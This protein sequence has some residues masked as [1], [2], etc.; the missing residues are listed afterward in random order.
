MCGARNDITESL[1]QIG[2]SAADA[3][4]FSIP[5]AVLRDLAAVVPLLPEGRVHPEIE[6]D[7]DDGSIVL[8]WF[9]QCMK[10]SLSLTF[11]GKGSVTGYISTSPLEAAWKVPV[12]DADFLRLQLTRN[13]AVMTLCGTKAVS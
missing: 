10:H 2:L 9:S 13:I 3:E 4:A 5:D 6:V 12:G 7:E 8:R 11:I 1:K